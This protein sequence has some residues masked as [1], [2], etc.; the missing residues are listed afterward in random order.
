MGEVEGCVVIGCEL[1][2]QPGLPLRLLLDHLDYLLY[3][4]LG[5]GGGDVL[6]DDPLVVLD[7]K[8]VYH[9]YYKSVVRV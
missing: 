3:P 4:L 7:G 8:S 2:G 5:G 1:D 9:L 6:F